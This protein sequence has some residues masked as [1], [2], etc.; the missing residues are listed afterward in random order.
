M[1]KIKEFVKIRIKSIHESILKLDLFNTE[2]SHQ[3][4]LNLCVHSQT[5][6]Y[7]LV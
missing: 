7:L 1:Y 3:Y 2:I 4:K 6:S 5:A